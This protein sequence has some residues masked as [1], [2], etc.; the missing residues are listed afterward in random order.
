VA[1]TVGVE[2]TAVRALLAGADALCLGHDL[3]DAAVESVCRAL[4]GAVREGRLPL[5]RLEEAAGRVDALAGWAAAP[6]PVAVTP[7]VGFDAARRAV[8]VDGD[9]RLDGPA[10]VVELLPEPN[11][12]AGL[13]EHSLAAALGASEGNGRLVI[14]VRDAHRHD[15]AR[16]ETERL[17]AEHPDA[18]V[19]ET[20][21][22]VW[23]PP[24]A[25]TYVTTNGAG[26]V[27]LEAAAEFLLDR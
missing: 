6:T 15:E 7:S 23:R 9:S 8:R 26:R 4:A 10:Q 21:L 11:I 27:N 16:R 1:D 24:T 18:I 25:R 19:V 12:A 13:H 20:G 3:G 14:V 5:D 22:P 17:L 2:E